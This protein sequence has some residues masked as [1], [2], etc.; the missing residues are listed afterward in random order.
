[1]PKPP[2]RPP[3]TKKTATVAAERVAGRAVVEKPIDPRQSGLFDQPVPKWIKPCLPT[4]VDKPP[5]GE[6]WIHEIKWDGYRVSAY[7]AAG[8]VTIR[9]RNGH[10][11]TSR[12]PA[13]AA[14][15]LKL[16]VRSAVIDGEAV[17]LDDMGR[18]NLAELQAALTKHGAE[19]AVLY[20]FDLLFL[21]GEDLRA[22]PLADRREALG[23]LM[24]PASAV[25]LSEE[26]AGSGDDLFR[27]ACEHELEGI[28][29]K[30]LDAPYRSGRSKTWFKTKCVLS[31]TFVIVGYQPTS[32]AVRGALANL[33][34][35]R[36]DGTTLEYVGAVGTGFSDAVATMLRERLDAIAT[37]KCAVEGLKT[38]GAVWVRP[39]LQAEIAYRGLTTARELRHASFKG[40]VDN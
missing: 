25:A 2:R 14:A 38:K 27:V 37:P 16:N 32:G 22:K 10:D 13:I 29:S 11:W 28:V 24:R 20:A 31:E 7:I 6:D 9:T 17:V 34:V 33:K 15:L 1:M 18:S 5:V 40:L 19:E 3:Q 35:A 36:F 23:F 4:L 26:Y 21:D 39:K 12:F 30:R 8:K